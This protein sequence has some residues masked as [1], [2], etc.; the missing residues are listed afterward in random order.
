MHYKV[1]LVNVLSSLFAILIVIGISAHDFSS[2]KPAKAQ[3][4]T[5]PSYGCVGCAPTISASPSL[6]SSQTVTITNN[7]PCAN[8][9]TTP[10][11]GKG[12]HHNDRGGFLKDLFQV[13]LLFLDLFLKLMG[14]N[15]PVPCTSVETTSPAPTN[16]L[17]ISLSPTSDTASLS[18]TPSVDIPRA[19]ASLPPGPFKTCKP[20]ITIDV[21]KA[22]EF[23][24]WL[25]NTV[26]PLLGNWY[27]VISDKVAQPEYAPTCSFKLVMDP[28]YDGIAQVEENNIIRMSTTYYTKHKTEMGSL[29]HEETHIIQNFN[30]SV[31]PLWITEGLADWVRDFI[32]QDR[33]PTKPQ[34]SDN[35]TTGYGT[36][37]AFFNYVQ[38]NYD[39]NLIHEL[40]VAAHNGTYTD[41]F[42]TQHTKKTVDQLW[43]EYKA[44][45]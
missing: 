18:A 37:A 43:A 7:T 9:V 5:S 14:P 35:Y 30:F 24:P 33:P 19:H 26:I 22:P 17:P 39:S 25:N 31:I 45:P 29:V 16:N 12:K 13:M 15:N 41:T 20:T 36:T 8:T 3:I 40:N 11:Q 23:A 44:A 21:S 10:T 28:S 34:A 1:I 42:W 27:Q 4:I 32:Y 2:K 38:K 6:L